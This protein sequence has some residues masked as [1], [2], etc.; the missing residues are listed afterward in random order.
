MLPVP[1]TST[2]SLRSPRKRLPQR[3]HFFRASARPA[4]PLAPPAHRPAGTGASAAPRR[5]GPTGAAHRPA[6]PTPACCSRPSTSCASSTEP[7][8]GYCSWY[9]SA[10]NPPKSC[11]VAGCGVGHD[12]GCARHPVRRHHDDAAQGRWCRHRWRTKARRG[13][14]TGW[15]GWQR[16]RKT[17]Q[18]RSDENFIGFTEKDKQ[19]LERQFVN[20]ITTISAAGAVRLRRDRTASPAAPHARAS[21]RRRPR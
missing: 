13:K 2:P 8:A 14:R 12:S 18:N 9:S 11:Q 6:R 10:G 5:R 15:A 20:P 19:A 21:P 7:G 16:S 17:P 3:K 4:A 1:I